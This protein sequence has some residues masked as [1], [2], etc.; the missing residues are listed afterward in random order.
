MVRGWASAPRPLARPV[1]LVGDGAT[2]IEAAGVVDLFVAYAGVVARPGVVDAAP[3][4]LRS[5]SLAPLVPL[6]L[7]Q[8]LPDH[9]AVRDVFRKGAR[10]IADGAL[11]WR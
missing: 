10:L 7:G 8:V 2:D 1:L 9:P 6:A 3:V 5:R 11:E 4:V